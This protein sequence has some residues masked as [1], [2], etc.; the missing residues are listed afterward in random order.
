MRLKSPTTRYLFNGLLNLTTKETPKLRMTGVL[1][2]GNP[3]ITCGF[4]SQKA[5]SA[6]DVSIS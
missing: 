1:C 5:N 2:E 6:E 3:P 4:P